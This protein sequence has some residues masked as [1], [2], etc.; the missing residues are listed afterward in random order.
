M[1]KIIFLI[2]IFFTMNSSFAINEDVILLPEDA[3]ESQR[4]RLEG[5]KEVVLEEELPSSDQSLLPDGLM[6]LCHPDSFPDTDDNA[7][8][9]VLLYK[10]PCDH[11]AFLSVIH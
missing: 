7:A 4:Q 6:H 10:L 5:E 1:K 8:L 2:L 3:I 11:L 9:H